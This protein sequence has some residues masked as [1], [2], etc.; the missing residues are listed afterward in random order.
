MTLCFV[1]V[2]LWLQIGRLVCLSVNTC[3]QF[4]DFSKLGGNIP[5]VNISHSNENID[6]TDLENEL[7]R[8][9]QSRFR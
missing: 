1:R 8:A 7:Y 4:S 2:L 6:H 9:I 5:R 3:N